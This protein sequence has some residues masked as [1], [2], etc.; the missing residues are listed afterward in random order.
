[1]A[2][3]LNEHIPGAQAELGIIVQGGLTH[4]LLR[5]LQMLGLADA[6][7]AS[8]IAL[9]V[10]NVTYPIVPQEVAA[11]CVGKRGVL[12]LEEGSPEY[13]E[14]DIL[15]AL[16]RQDIQTPLFGK[17]LMAAHG[18]YN[19]EVLARGLL[20][21]CDETATDAAPRWPRNWAR[22]CPHARRRFAS[23]VPSGRCFRH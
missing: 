15:A 11:F 22:R 4:S 8:Q 10:L 7:G 17:A 21:F 18:E 19:V 16:H 14:N 5:A 6:F 1:V 20:R 23:A 13:I 2:H 9:L 3:K 12:V